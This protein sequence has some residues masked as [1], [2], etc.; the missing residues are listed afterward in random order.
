M[1]KIKYV[2]EYGLPENN[3]EK[4]SFTLSS[5]KK[6]DYIVSVL[7]RI[8]ERVEL[9]SPSCT[10]NFR[11]YR[12]R[13]DRLNCMTEVLSGPAV[14]ERLGVIG[15]IFTKLWLLVYLLMNTKQND[16]VIVYHGKTKIPFI[17]LAKKII[18]F[19]MILEVEEIYADLLQDR[20]GA[21][22][23]RMEMRMLKKADAFIFASKELELKYNIY[24]KPSVVAN[25]S[26]IVNEDIA[27]N[28]YVGLDKKIRLV[29]AGLIKK[30]KVAFRCAEIANYLDSKYQIKIIGYGDDG[31]VEALKQYIKKLNEN[32]GC[33]VEYDGLK[34]GNDYNEYLQSCTIGLC[35]LNSSDKFQSACFPSKITSY[36]SNGL[37]VITTMN[38]VVAE[39][40]YK[41]YVMFS[42]SELP[43]KFAEAIMRCLDSE[44]NRID[45]RSTIRLLDLKFLDQCQMLLKKMRG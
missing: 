18:N 43:Q 44:Q 12:K 14:P 6:I 24:G 3:I 29:Y 35:P 39:S 25:G 16:V 28:Q 17:L 13:I 40:P 7:N 10:R 9:V 4:R 20:T 8:G 32:N 22:L 21:I 11:F 15:Q 42:E 36:L 2:C 45:P 5:N 27:D 41:D 34:S 37:M 33:I 31:D 30:G 19:K 1:T 23:R 38:K 26:Y